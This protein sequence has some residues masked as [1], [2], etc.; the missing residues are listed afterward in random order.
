M[1]PA[2][3]DFTAL[4]AYRD[5]LL[6]AFKDLLLRLVQGLKDCL[7]DRLLLDCP[8]CGPGD[9]IYLATV[10][11]RSGQVYHI[12]NFLRREVLTF[13]KVK[14]WLSA[15][16]V[17][18]IIHWLVEKFCCSVLPELSGKINPGSFM[19]VPT[20]NAIFEKIQTRNFKLD[21]SSMSA[22]YGA[23]GKYAFQAAATRALLP[24]PA[25][26]IPSQVLEASPQTATA[27]LAR[28]GVAVANV[29][30]YHTALASNLPLIDPSAVPPNFQPGD[31][32]NLYTQNGRVVYYTRVTTPAAAPAPASAGTAPSPAVGVAEVHDLQSQLGALRAQI[33][34]LQQAHAEAL[35]QIAQLNA[36]TAALQAR[37]RP[38]GPRNTSS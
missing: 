32:V 14:Y 38:P 34:S 3:V 13:P 18:P 12:C 25:P 27:V 31:Q 21:L 33:T 37:R 28:Y 23:S 15:V 2:P 29:A 4:S 7:C 30:D 24:S 16:P 19:T 17:I 5:S 20:T 9:V 26:A 11:I 6:A 1:A 36:A 35:Q 22:R 8:R 10:E